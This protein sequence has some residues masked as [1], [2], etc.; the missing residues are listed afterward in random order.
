MFNK[1]KMNVF[2]LTK[3][4]I[5]DSNRKPRPWNHNE[6]ISTR[7]DAL[8]IW[9]TSWSKQ[10]L[11]WMQRILWHTTGELAWKWETPVDY[12]LGIE[13]TTYSWAQH[14][15]TFLTILRKLFIYLKCQATH[16]KELEKRKPLHALVPSPTLYSNTY[17][18]PGG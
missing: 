2:F 16:G 11:P 6:S 10:K 12:H 8:L 3:S 17:K 13:I 15:E 9:D 14:P 5:L 4:N 7:H 18:I 1:L